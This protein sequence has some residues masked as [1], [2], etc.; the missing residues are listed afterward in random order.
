MNRQ[1][2]PVTSSFAPLLN[3]PYSSLADIDADGDFDLIMGNSAGTISTY[4]NQ[5]GVFK[6]LYGIIDP[7]DGVDI[8]S[9][10]APTFIDIDADGDPDAFIGE[11]D[12]IINFF[13]NDNG[14]FSQKF[15]STNPL[16]GVYIDQ[17][18]S[19][20]FI[21]IDLDDDFDAFIGNQEGTI[22]FF[23]NDNGSF[24]ELTGV[25]NPLNSIDVG[26]MSTPTF[27]DVDQD[28]DPDLFVGEFDAKINFFRND[29]GSFVE[30]TGGNN[31][32]DGIFLDQFVNVDFVDIDHDGD[33]DAFIGDPQNFL[34]SSK[35]VIH[36]V[37]NNNGIF[38]EEVV[39]DF[40]F[41]GF[42]VGFN[43]AP[44]FADIDIDGDEDA[45]I[46]DGLGRI[47]SFINNN[48]L[49]EEVAG[50]AN[51]FNGI[52]VGF[53]AKP[54]LID[55]DAT[56]SD[57]DFD[58]VVG[59]GD[60]TIHYYRNNNGSF[61][62]LIGANN[63][64][65][66]VNV[67][68]RAAPTFTDF[69]SD[70]DKDAFVGAADGTIHYFRNDNGVFIEQL[71]VN[72]PFNGID[73]GSNSTPTFFR[74]NQDRMYVGNSEGTILEF[75]KVGQQYS[76]VADSPFLGIDVGEDSTPTIEG[77][78][79]YVGNSKGKIIWFSD[80][81]GRFNIWQ[82]PFTSNW[83]GPTNNWELMTI[84]VAGCDDVHVFKDL[85]LKIESSQVAESRT[86]TVRQTGQFEVKSG[87]ELIVEPD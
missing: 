1:P 21:D 76:V 25:D 80:N 40:T 62:E 5:N 83:H 15:G 3:G 72:N 38:I 28:G 34:G 41:N 17:R 23:R 66:G 45:F 57:K 42:D 36:F 85:V 60:G 24:I 71:G 81:G 70:N 20:T 53:S 32:L 26:V 69:D 44:T 29:N 10:S 14:V 82:G 63:P 64:F 31:P 13:R 73:V 74:F 56:D 7:F 37:R 30:M 11:S 49:R 58:L 35:S 77:N 48:G 50:L 2:I 4:E 12:G 16:N 33:E 54:V 8:G 52:D 75:K 87:A 79:V 51:P 27:T 39:S 43:S 6:R 65:S 86:L 9:R 61:N 59:A 47:R 84:P 67:G 55:I 46:G 18:S 22:Q 68:S 19:P 78:N